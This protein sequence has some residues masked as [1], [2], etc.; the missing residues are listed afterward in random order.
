MLWICS[1]LFIRC[2]IKRTRVP[3][4]AF[5]CIGEHNDIARVAYLSYRVYH[6]AGRYHSK[7]VS[8]HEKSKYSACT[9]WENDPVLASETSIRQRVDL[10]SLSD[11]LAEKTM[12]TKSGR[13]KM[14][15]DYLI[16]SVLLVVSGV[17]I[18]AFVLVILF[19]A[20][21]TPKLMR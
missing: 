14:P 16:W 13:R 11:N 20:A 15:L 4:R 2:R 7:M 3:L 9:T 17:S 12:V 19:S 10:S 8:T 18:C 6:I 21:R 1:P 5:S